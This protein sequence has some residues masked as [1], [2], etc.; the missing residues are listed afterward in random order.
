MLVIDEQC[1]LN[2]W[3]QTGCEGAQGSPIT[4]V[5]EQQTG[6]ESLAVLGPF[7]IAPGNPPR[8]VAQSVKVTCPNTSK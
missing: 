4:L 8:E 7:I 2:F 3:N 6:C 1:T 5:G